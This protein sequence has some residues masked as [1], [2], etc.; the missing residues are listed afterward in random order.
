MVV[1]PVKKRADGG[2]GC[3]HNSLQASRFQLR[4]LPHSPKMN[5][6]FS[7]FGVCFLP[8]AS[9]R[10]DHTGRKSLLPP[11][12]AARTVVQEPK[13]YTKRWSLFGVNPSMLE[14]CEVFDPTGAVTQVVR[15]WRP[16]QRQKETLLR[17]I[18][19][20]WRRDV[21]DDI[22]KHVGTGHGKMSKLYAL[23]RETSGREKGG[24][25]RSGAAEAHRGI[26]EE[27]KEEGEKRGRLL[28][29][30]RYRFLHTGSEKLYRS[31]SL[32][33]L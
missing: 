2:G 10:N 29:V 18:R 24:V 31:L 4:Q 22:I 27:H 7:G 11:H 5:R 8:V 3:M 9:F 32:K 28:D 16:T 23:A 19:G 15:T 17:L 14:Y 30:E 1:M 12:A 25:E 20:F 33:Q 21:N 13:S 26:K 6:L